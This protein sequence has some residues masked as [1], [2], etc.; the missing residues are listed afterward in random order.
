MR[1][2]RTYVLNNIFKLLRNDF[3]CIFFIIMSVDFYLKAILSPKI[4]P[5]EI[6]YYLKFTVQFFFLCLKKIDIFSSFQMASE[7]TWA[8]VESREDG[9]ADMVAAQ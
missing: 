4:L 7:T 6:R 5:T 8:S 2:R 1:Y 9:E 3:F